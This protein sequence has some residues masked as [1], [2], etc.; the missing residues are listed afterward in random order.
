[1]GVRE[2]GGIK[3]LEIG[4]EGGVVG[5]KGG[6]CGDAGKGRVRAYLDQ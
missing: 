1:M 5:K 3:G 2:R 4:G 6:G